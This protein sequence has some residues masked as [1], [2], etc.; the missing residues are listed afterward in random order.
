MAFGDGIKGMPVMEFSANLKKLG[1][2][3]KV[4]RGWVEVPDQNC[5][6]FYNANERPNCILSVERR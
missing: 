5:V 3:H 4:H 1:I 6:V 2:E